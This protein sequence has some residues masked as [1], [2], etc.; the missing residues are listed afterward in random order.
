VGSY[1]ISDKKKLKLIKIIKIN[2]EKEREKELQKKMVNRQRNLVTSVPDVPFLSR[3]RRNGKVIIVSSYSVEIPGITAHSAH[4]Q[5]LFLYSQ[6]FTPR[7]RRI[8]RFILF[9]RTV[10]H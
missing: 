2:R 7:T 9:A 5:H 10:L 1:E 6:T 3:L 8:N 4:I